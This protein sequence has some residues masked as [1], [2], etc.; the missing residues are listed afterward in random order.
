MTVQT[1]VLPS[2][3]SI[4]I[5]SSTGSPGGVVDP[6][7]VVGSFSHPLGNSA[8]AVGSLQTG[9]AGLSA[10]PAGCAEANEHRTEAIGGLTR[11]VAG[12][13]ATI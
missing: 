3:L 13:Q 10:F 4:W 6:R 7:L 5:S 2:A 1:K 12:T 8:A 11:S 9:Y